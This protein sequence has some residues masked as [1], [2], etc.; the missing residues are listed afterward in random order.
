MRVPIGH[1]QA[2]KATIFSIGIGG[3]VSRVLLL[4][5]LG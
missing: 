5:F 3:S 2:F 4:C 1:D